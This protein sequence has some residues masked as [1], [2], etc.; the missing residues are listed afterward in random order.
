[1]HVR[2]TG[3]SLLLLFAIYVVEEVV[4]TKEFLS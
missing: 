1:M 4:K 2:G 3:K